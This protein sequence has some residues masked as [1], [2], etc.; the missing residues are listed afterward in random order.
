MVMYVKRYDKFAAVLLTDDP[1]CLASF[2]ANDNGLVT[3]SE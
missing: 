1:I 2:A 3:N